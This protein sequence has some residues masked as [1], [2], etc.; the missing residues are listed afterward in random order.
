MFTLNCVGCFF[1]LRYENK[2]AESNKRL[3][4]TRSCYMVFATPVP[5]IDGWPRP[6]RPGIP[7]PL[8][9]FKIVVRVFC[10]SG[11][12]TTRPSTEVTR[13]CTCPAIRDRRRISWAYSPRTSTAICGSTSRSSF[14]RTRRLWYRYS[15]PSVRCVWWPSGCFTPG[16]ITYG[17]ASPTRSCTVRY[18]PPSYPCS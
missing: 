14:S 3:F 12:R 5:T 4:Y 8:P 13:R 7:P 15:L 1:V 2:F 9:S 10:F 6:I 11:S 18:S 17:C 16:S